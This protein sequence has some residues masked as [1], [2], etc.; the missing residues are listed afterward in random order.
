[1]KATYTSVNVKK[2]KKDRE[3]VCV[4]KEMK[5]TGYKL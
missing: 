4:K 5:K 2:K 1:M 3:R